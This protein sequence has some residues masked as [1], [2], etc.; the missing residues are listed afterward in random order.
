VNL[1]YNE[2]IQNESYYR[3][4]LLHLTNRGNRY[5][6]DKCLETLSIIL[7]KEQSKDF[8][9]INDLNVLLDICLREIQT[10]KD[11]N[12]R[13]QIL[14]M[15]ETII[16][17]DM[18]KQYPYKLDDIRDTVN[19]LVL[20]EDESQGGYSIKEKE[21]ISKLNLKFQMFSF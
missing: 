20:Y 5:R 2:F 7:S 8:F 3:E 21:F 15:I 9:N 11:P 1:A 16:D 18:Y 17:H 12:V 14:R 6:F 10:E 13:V 4:K 19:E